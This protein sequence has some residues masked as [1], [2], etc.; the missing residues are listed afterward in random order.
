[1]HENNVVAHWK[2]KVCDSAFYKTASMV[3][4]WTGLVVGIMIDKELISSEDDLVC[5]YI[6]EW[7]DGCKYNVTIKNLLTM[8]AGLNRK[9]GAEGRKKRVGPDNLH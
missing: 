7:K 5:Q 4:S 6:P 8:T 9:R 2:N 3:K 1:M